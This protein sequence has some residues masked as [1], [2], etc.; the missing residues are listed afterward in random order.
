MNGSWRGGG[1]KQQRGNA[2]K[3]M[4]RCSTSLIIQDMVVKTI[5]DKTSLPYQIGKNPKMSMYYC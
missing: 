4:E 2:F 1:T 5:G 3:H